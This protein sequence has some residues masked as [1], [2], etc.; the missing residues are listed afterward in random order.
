[1]PSRSLTTW[2]ADARRALD[3]IEAA[4][5]AVGRTGRGSRY[6]A[7]QINQA[8]VLLLSSWF[9]RFCRDLHTQCVD[10]LVGG[11]P[12]AI[13]MIVRS[14]FI[15]GRKLDSGNPNPGNIGSDF[16]RLGIPF[17]PTVRSLRG[18]VGGH[19]QALISMNRWRNAVAHQDFSHPD[20]KGAHRLRLADVR[21]WRSACD[22]LAMDFEAVMYDYL[23]YITG[24]VPW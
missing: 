11:T 17:W 12:V 14:Q 10:H 2:H 7:Q 15:T 6:A 4:H 13:Q 9:Q 23:S 8:Y 5:R 24:S 20:L 19:Q 3:E 21:G 22:R 16:D 1:M 18:N